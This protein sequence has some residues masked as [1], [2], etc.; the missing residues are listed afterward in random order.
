MA[1]KHGERVYKIRRVTDGLFSTGGDTPT[2]DKAG[3]V[4]RKLAH[5]RSHFAVTGD[6]RKPRVNPGADAYPDC[7][8]VEYELRE[9]GTVAVDGCEKG[10]APCASKR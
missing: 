10:A 9:V 4:W 8:V 7:L 2:F 5:V 1:R 3:K 6:W